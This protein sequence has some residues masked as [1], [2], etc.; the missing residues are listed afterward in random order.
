MSISDVNYGAVAA[1]TVV[2]FIIGAIWYMPIFGKIWGQIH[3]F[4][5]LSKK[6]QAAAQKQMMPL[7]GVQ[8]LITILSAFGLTY[9]I[10]ALP[11]NNAYALGLL[12]W[13]AFMVPT[14]A[15]AVIFGGTEPRWVGTKTA[16]MI[17]GSLA[18]TMAAALVISLIV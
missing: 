2:Q 12:V 14:Q 5:K 3:G 17:G 13:L 11:S 4:D 6:E 9:L 15:S 10:Q 1:A 7:I 18:C 8:F 16:I